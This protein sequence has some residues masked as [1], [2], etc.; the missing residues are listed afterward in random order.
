VEELR[1]RVP[2]GTKVA[3]VAMSDRLA[4]AAGPEVAA[5]PHCRLVAQ[6]GFDD[7]PA[8]AA[9]GLTTIRQDSGL[10]GEMAVKVLLDGLK[11]ATLPVEL[12]VRDT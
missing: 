5:W 10:K 3:L 8:A 6:V 11:G 12:V 2:P 1:G 7:I 9:A 4:L